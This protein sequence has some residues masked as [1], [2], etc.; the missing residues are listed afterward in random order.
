MAEEVLAGDWEAM[1]VRIVADASA[2]ESAFR[3]I[4]ISMPRRSGHG[5]LMRALSA[6]NEPR[7]L[8]DQAVREWRAS[9]S[10]TVRFLSIAECPR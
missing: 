2:V 9:G 6:A 4:S 5:A 7:R 8:A 10:P 3:R 1:M